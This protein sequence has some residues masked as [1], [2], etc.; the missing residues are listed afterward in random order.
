MRRM[1]NQPTISNYTSLRAS[2][3]GVANVP[4]AEFLAHLPHQ[5]QKTPNI[6]CAKSHNFY[7]M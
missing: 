3:V 7:N 6:K 2:T 4:N 5:T 1:K